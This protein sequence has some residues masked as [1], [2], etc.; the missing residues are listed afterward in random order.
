MKVRPFP[1]A[2]IKDMHSYLI[3]L[4]EKKPK[5]IIVHVSTNDAID[6]SSIELTNELMQLKEFIEISLPGSVVILSFPIIRLDNNQADSNL[7]KLREN[8]VSLNINAIENNNI[9][10]EH[11]GKFG[12]HLN[13]KGSGR[14][15]MNYISCIRHL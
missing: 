11:L 8:L 2:K 12:L 6:K 7:I 1:G 13:A 3:P 15:A 9:T 5:Y 14:L 10:K 4:I